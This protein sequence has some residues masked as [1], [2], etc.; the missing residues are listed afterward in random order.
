MTRTTIEGVYENGVVK[1]SE[2]PPTETPMKVMVVF[3]EEKKK[4][5]TKERKPGAMKGI[6]KYIAPDFDEPLE[7]LKEYI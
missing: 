1:L 6:I 4:E 7:E 3:I 5:L 2:M